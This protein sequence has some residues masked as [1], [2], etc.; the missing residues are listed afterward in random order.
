MIKVTHL[1]SP[2]W[3][4]EYLRHKDSHRSYGDTYEVA[5]E[6]F[7]CE[8][9]EPFVC[10]NG[11]SFTM[12]RVNHSYN[13]D[14]PR[15]GGPTRLPRPLINEEWEVEPKKFFVPRSRAQCAEGIWDPTDT[16][17][18]G[19][20]VF[21]AVPESVA[22]GALEAAKEHAKAHHIAENA[23]DMIVY[24]ERAKHQLEWYSEDRTQQEIES[25]ITEAEKK[26]TEATATIE[27]WE[28][29]ATSHRSK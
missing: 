15:R 17:N 8:A 1:G 13:Y 18:P 25:L 9:V 24:I 19:T 11:E 14:V 5:V 22:E 23:K 6:P 20:M 16:L 4:G 2:S 28:Q 27:A 10:E 7:V 21:F 3:D 26:R 12:V 29:W